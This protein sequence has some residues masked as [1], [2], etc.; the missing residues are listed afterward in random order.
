MVSGALLPSRGALFPALKSIGL[1][2]QAIRR[3]WGA[4]RYGKWQIRDLVGEWRSYVKGLEDWHEHRFEGFLP[5]ALDITAAWR[6]R[7]KDCPS[8][9]YPPMAGE[10]EPAVIIGLAGEVGEIN[11]QRLVLPRVIERVHPAD[12]SETRLWTELFKQVR[13]GLDDQDIVVVDAGVKISHLHEVEIGNFVI[14]LASNFTAQR[15]A[16]PLHTRGRKPMY[17]AV[18]R[19]LARR[20]DGQTKPFTSPD[21]CHVW[22][23]KG[24]RISVNIWRNLVLPKTCPDPLNSTF[25]VYAFHDPDFKH[26]WLLACSVKLRFES[27]HA[28]YSDRWA[29]EQIPLSAKQMLGAHRQ[30]VHAPESVQR[31]PELVLLAGNILSMVAALCK[32]QPTGFWD[33]NPSATPGRLRR[34]LFGQPFPKYA[35][36]GRV[37]KKHSATDHLPRGHLARSHPL[38]QNPPS[39]N[40]L[41]T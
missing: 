41:A 38:P 3:A 4:F 23:V 21:E 26:P 18:V 17:G 33:L 40:P 15:N 32:P 19:P 14:R 29:I 27:V 11:G 36:L 37:R 10:A 20:Y 13:K 25:D 35:L 8:K 9:H 6:L 5:V 1:S 34:A 24:H 12:P 16:L 28:I 39:S 30:F 7:L 2:D 22:V 31:M